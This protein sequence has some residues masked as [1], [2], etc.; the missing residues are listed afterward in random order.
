MEHFL[1]VGPIEQTS[2]IHWT[3][4]YFESEQDWS[5]H[6]SSLWTD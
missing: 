2:P 3:S 4:C 6:W 1:S 5:R